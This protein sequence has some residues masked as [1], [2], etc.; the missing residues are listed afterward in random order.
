MN[1][2]Y[3]DASALGKRYVPENGS[4]L[5]NHLFGM[6]S[7][8]RM[9]ALLIVAGEVTSILVRRRNRDQLN[10][11]DYRHAMNEF[12]REVLDAEDFRL[13]SV[14]PD[15]AH[16]SLD[17]IERHS[18]N[19]TDALVLRSALDLAQLLRLV[20]DALVLVAAD[21]RLLRA[22]EA[23]GLATLNPEDGTVADVD[24]LLADDSDE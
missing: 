6:L 16:E 5:V 17:L 2:F 15:L 4:G 11:D 13:Q 10:P 1:S 20:G 21:A 14:P 12:R 19:A 3:W 9:V 18:L 8:D 23:E 22:A 24:A 7:P